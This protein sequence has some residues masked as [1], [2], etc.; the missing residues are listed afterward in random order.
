MPRKRQLDPSFWTNGEVASLKD[1]TKL[2]YMGSWNFADDHGVFPDKP[3]ELR[4]SIFPYNPQVKVEK[5]IEELVAAEKLI[6]YEVDGKKFYWIKNFIKHQKID[7]P[8]YKYPLSESIRREIAKVRQELATNRVEKSRVEKSKEP[9]FKK[10]KPYFKGNEM[11]KSFGKWWVLEK[12]DWL[13]FAGLES[14]ITWQ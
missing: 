13:E 3:K 10:L 7:Y 9:S 4:V 5:Y 11:R 1:K 8:T 12:G 14:E 6:P 2:F